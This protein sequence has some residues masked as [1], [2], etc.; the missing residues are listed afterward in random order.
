MPYPLIKLLDNVEETSE[1]K[2]A[3]QS[4][5]YQLLGIACGIASIITM[6]ANPLEVWIA[7]SNG[8]A[9]ITGF[10]ILLAI[11]A[12]L[13]Y[14]VLAPALTLAMPFVIGFSAYGIGVLA[15][16][17]FNELLVNTVKS[18]ICKEP[19]MQNGSLHFIYRVDSTLFRDRY[20]IWVQ[21]YVQAGGCVFFKYELQGFIP[22]RSPVLSL[23]NALCSQHKFVAQKDEE[24][25]YLNRAI[26]ALD[27]GDSKVE[28]LQ[29]IRDKQETILAE[30]YRIL[31]N[32][33]GNKLL[34]VLGDRASRLKQ[35]LIDQLEGTKSA[36]S[37]FQSERRHMLEY[38]SVPLQLRRGGAGGL[39]DISEL[40]YKVDCYQMDQLI[41]ESYLIEQAYEEIDRY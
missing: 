3:V 34:G 7:I 19:L 14:I 15:D 31:E 22:L 18:R 39:V 9:V 1:G 29:E 40:N 13:I 36:I 2:T 33:S 25:D 17:G 38:L 11:V 23:I 32:K 21:K 16:M 41:E 4:S 37:N 28:A 12:G 26:E 10:P 8:W 27:I 6:L 30:I 5:R 20:V 24:R 35:R